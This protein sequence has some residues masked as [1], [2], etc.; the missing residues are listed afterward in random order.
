MPDPEI[1]TDEDMFDFLDALVDTDPMRLLNMACQFYADTVILR[2][3]LTD[4]R[5]IASTG[6]VCPSDA[7]VIRRVDEVLR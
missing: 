5:S 1:T 2:A 3:A 6:K 4:V 7:Q